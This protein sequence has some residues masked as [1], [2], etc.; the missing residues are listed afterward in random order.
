MD[1]KLFLAPI[2]DNP[3]KIVDLGTG[4]GMWAQDGKVHPSRSGSQTNSSVVAVAENF[5][6]ARVIGTDL[7]PIQ[8]HWTPPN[9]EFRVEDLEDENRSWTSIY[10]DADL[11]HIRALL[12]TLRKP[13]QLLERAF[14]WVEMPHILS[15]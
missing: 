3:Q 10:A 14:Q 12:Q 9:V 7:S 2:G 4:V 5:P 1:G 11:I 8:P 15:L 13:R 6:S